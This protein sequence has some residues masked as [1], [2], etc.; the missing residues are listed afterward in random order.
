MG[1]F[2]PRQGKNISLTEFRFYNK[3]LQFLSDEELDKI[4][5]NVNANPDK[6]VYWTNQNF[7]QKRVGFVFSKQQY[8]RDEQAEIIVNTIGIDKDVSVEMFNSTKYIIIQKVYLM[9]DLLHNQ[10]QALDNILNKK[11]DYGRNI[12]ITKTIFL[13]N[14]DKVITTLITYGILNLYHASNWT[15]FTDDMK[16]MFP[17]LFTKEPKIDIQ[18]RENSLYV[19]KV[20]EKRIDNKNY[21]VAFCANTNSY[22]VEWAMKVFDEDNKNY[23]YIDEGRVMLYA[24][25]STYYFLDLS[26]TQTTKDGIL[27][28]NDVYR[29]MMRDINT[30]LPPNQYVITPQIYRWYKERATRFDSYGTVRRKDE[31]YEEIV[32][33]Y[34]N[35]LTNNKKIKIEN[36][37]ITNKSI[38]IEG[39]NFKAEFTKEFIDIAYHI[40]SIRKV[41]QKEDMKYNFNILWEELLKMSSIAVINRLNTSNEDYK[42]FEKANFTVNGM[43]ITVSKDSNRININGTFCRIEDAYYILTKCICYNDVNEY[44]K[45]VKEVSYIGIEWKKM[46]SNGVLIEIYNPFFK[47]F[48]ESG[49]INNLS[50]EKIYLRFSLKWN[51]THRR[52][53][54][55]SVN[56]TD[57]LIKN[58]IKF[59]KHFNHPNISTSI[60]I[61]RHYLIESID[62]IQDDDIIT[63]IQ[64][65]IE[66]AKI[67]KERGKELLKNTV[68]DT[69]ATEEDVIINGIS[70]KGYKLIGR[71]TGSMYFIKIED[72]SVFKLTDG[73]WNRRCIVDNVSKHR[74]YEDR[75]AN[76]LVN[77]YNEPSYLH[78]VLR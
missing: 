15:S 7:I 53:I 6:Y 29:L 69:K 67:V 17:T 65:G 25:N 4:I 36:T 12:E 68:V 49:Y 57:Y 33:V 32:N 24:Q 18:S 27:I 63:I 54:H 55:L 23:N 42:K 44:N 10:I 11:R 72:L 2:D 60:S 5:L 31:T 41:L 48:T 75:L 58:K 1:I 21:R 50:M 52:H 39:T 77:I 74:I 3:A 46:I 16:V 66:E 70:Y 19:Y 22:S 47:E 43:D 76:R 13:H 64:N 30:L 14:W 35:L 37:F 71:V 56:E 40:G 51:M 34:R 20:L 9:F 8:R 45:Y 26:C 59:R 62:E 38:E 73:N 28:E 61:L 78:N